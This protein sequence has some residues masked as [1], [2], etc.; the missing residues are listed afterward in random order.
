[1]YNFP[2]LV[3]WVCEH[4][5]L[6]QIK[7]IARDGKVVL[8]LTPQTMHTM[9]FFRDRKEMLPLDID[10]LPQKFTALTPQLRAKLLPMHLNKGTPTPQTYL[11]AFSVELITPMSRIAVSTIAQVLC[12]E[13]GL[14]V[15]STILGFLVTMQSPLDNSFAQFY[16]CT[17]IAESMHS[18][19][20]DFRATRSFRH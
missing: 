16:L 3:H 13:S 18:Q 1:M 2:E 20:K 15:E 9:L 4:Y 7:V 10:T 8:N 5:Y 12:L 11:L 6:Y 19:L 14:V 17:F